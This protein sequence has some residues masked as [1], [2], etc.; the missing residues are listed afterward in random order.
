M[1]SGR[2]LLFGLPK[3]LR[4]VEETSAHRPRAL[5]QQLAMPK[6]V[7]WRYMSW[8]TG[9]LSFGSLI[10]SRRAGYILS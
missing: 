2:A 4:R 3:V 6:D 5:Q 7:A 10:D 9:N 1:I 8:A